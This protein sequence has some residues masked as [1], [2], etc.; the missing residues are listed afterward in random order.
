MGQSSGN[1]GEGVRS[2]LVPGH[3]GC[4]ES[5]ESKVAFSEAFETSKGRDLPVSYKIE[6]SAALDSSWQN[7]SF[8]F[9]AGSAN[10]PAC[11]CLVCS[12][13]E[14]VNGPNGQRSLPPLSFC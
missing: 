11:F 9:I 4:G 3:K 1:D 14:C 5:W 7:R 2:E 8:W 13:C 12:C 6:A 10:L